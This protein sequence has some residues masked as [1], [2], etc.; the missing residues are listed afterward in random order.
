MSQSAV[1]VQSICTVAKLV[2]VILTQVEFAG[3]H[4]MDWWGWLLLMCLF[5]LLD[6]IEVAV[7]CSGARMEGSL[8]E[9]SIVNWA[10]DVQFGILL[11]IFFTEF[12]S[13]RFYETE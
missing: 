8:Y 11:L 12:G 6:I 1:A 5:Y 7:S 3:T 4:V 9:F 2:L 10:V 13:S